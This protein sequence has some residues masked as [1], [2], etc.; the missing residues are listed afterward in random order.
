MITRID[1]KLHSDL[2]LVTPADDEA[3]SGLMPR[4]TFDRRSVGRAFQDNF[5]TRNK[6]REK[7]TLPDPSWALFC[8]LALTSL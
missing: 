6:K 7:V 5:L 3:L 8:N 2:L 1:L 4:K